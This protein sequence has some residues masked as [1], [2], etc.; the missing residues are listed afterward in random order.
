GSLGINLAAAVDITLTDSRVVR[1]LTG[2]TG[3]IYHEHST[4]GA[5]L[6]SRS[7]TSLAGLVFLPGVIDADCTG[8]IQVVAYPLHPPMVI[9]KGTRIAQLLLYRKEAGH[10]DSAQAPQRGPQGFGSTGNTV[11]GLTQQMKTRP[12]ITVML[13]WGAATHRMSQVMTDTG[14]DVTIM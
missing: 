8:E 14:A 12:L 7:S 10:E 4:M 5:L 3:P 6:I 11:V 13:E 9:K 2:V 1:I